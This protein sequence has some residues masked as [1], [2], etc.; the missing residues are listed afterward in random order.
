MSGS[1]KTKWISNA[2]KPANGWSTT[3]RSTGGFYDPAGQSSAAATHL[4]Y[5]PIG[6][7]FTATLCLVLVS[8]KTHSIAQ[9]QKKFLSMHKEVVD[10]IIMERK[11]EDA[12]LS[13]K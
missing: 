3:R 10:R 11:L 7:M 4:H 13:D 9:S 1:E 5:G 2:L 12:K 8:M 6:Y